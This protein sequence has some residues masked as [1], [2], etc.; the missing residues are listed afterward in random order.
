M[1][2]FA[3]PIPVEKHCGTV[4]DQSHES[5]RIISG[6]ALHTSRTFALTDTPHLQGTR[7]PGT[8]FGHVGIGVKMGERLLAGL[9]RAFRGMLAAARDTT[10]L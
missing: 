3:G 6:V 5:F 4:F 10:M 8:Q 2:S 9:P 7:S 1:T